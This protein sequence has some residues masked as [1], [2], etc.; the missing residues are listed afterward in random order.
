MQIVSVSLFVVSQVIVFNFRNKILHSSL[1][2]Y[3][4]I[5]S[6]IWFPHYIVLSKIRACR[7]THEESFSFIYFCVNSCTTR[8]FNY[9][10]E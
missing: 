8:Y 10:N 4:S 5:S 6:S 2:S 7:K 9:K 3:M 1:F